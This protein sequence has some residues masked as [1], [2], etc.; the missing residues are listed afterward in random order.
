MP[1]FKKQYLGFDLAGA[2]CK[3]ATFQYL[4]FSEYTGVK[5]VMD[6]INIRGVK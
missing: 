3:T 2:F 5:R 6:P 1:F 4:V